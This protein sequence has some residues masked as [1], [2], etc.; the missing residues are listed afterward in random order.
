[1]DSIWC[2]KDKDGEIHYF[3]K[4]E[5]AEKYQDMENL[6]DCSKWEVALDAK[7]DISERPWLHDVET[8]IKNNSI[9]VMKRNGRDMWFFNHKNQEKI[10]CIYIE[11]NILKTTMYQK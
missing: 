2:V 3:S 11:N 5:L 9:T 8:I 7:D 10:V 1:M 4:L 6:F